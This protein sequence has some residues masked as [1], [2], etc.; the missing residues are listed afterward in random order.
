MKPDHRQRLIGTAKLHMRILEHLLHDVSPEKANSLR[1]GVDGWNT[2]EIL[3]HLRDFDAIF[4]ERAQ[5]IL[6][7]DE[8]SLVPVDH[9]ALVIENQYATQ[10]LE[11][12]LAQLRTS[13]DATLAVFE[14]VAEDAWERVGIHPERGRFSL[15]DA[16]LQV[17]THDADH[18]EQ[19]TRVLAQG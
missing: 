4:R 13:R 9:E 15:E 16:L 19:I 18:T 17:V 7:E 14:S 1:D 6:A 5:R 12:A 8:P 2:V 3:C 10:Q 11:T